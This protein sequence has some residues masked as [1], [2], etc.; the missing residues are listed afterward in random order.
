MAFSRKLDIEPN[1]DM[2]LRSPDGFPGLKQS[3]ACLGAA[4]PPKNSGSQRH[5][6][7]EKAIAIHAYCVDDSIELATV[8]GKQILTISYN[9]E[10]GYDEWQSVK[11]GL[12]PFVRLRNDI[13]QGDYRAL[14]ITWM[15]A[16][17]RYPDGPEAD[18]TP[19]PPLPSGLKNLNAALKRLAELIAVDDHLIEAAA[20]NSL[21]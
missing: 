7:L 5:S 18:D 11:D 19:E 9:E 2:S 12:S 10:G 6:F 1:L 8:E 17:G 14:Y 21:R 13:L 20:E 15:G 3:P 4:T 16:M